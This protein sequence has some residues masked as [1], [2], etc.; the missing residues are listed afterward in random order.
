MY[1]LHGNRVSLRE[2]GSVCDSLIYAYFICGIGEG[3]GHRG[4]WGRPV[5]SREVREVYSEQP[6]AGLVDEVSVVAVQPAG[7]ARRE[8]NLADVVGQAYRS[9]RGIND[10]ELDARRRIAGQTNVPS[11]GADPKAAASGR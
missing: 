4:R 10:G 1:E 6:P 8:K 7:G 2:R 9:G 11:R 5:P 3:R